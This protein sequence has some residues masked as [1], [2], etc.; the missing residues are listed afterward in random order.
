LIVVAAAAMFAAPGAVPAALADA[1]PI[2]AGGPGGRIALL[3]PWT[4]T[5]DSADHGSLKGWQAGVFQGTQVQVPFVPNAMPIVGRPGI[6]SYRGTVAWYRT[7]FN[8]PSDGVY[9]LHFES[10]HHHASIWLDDRQLGSHTG[11]YLP[12]EYRVSLQARTPHTLVVRADWRGPAAM[13]RAGWHRTWFNFGG[14]NREVT[15]R[16]V[17]ASDLSAPTIRTRLDG[18]TALVDVTVHVRNYA[19][20]RD[21]PIQGSL[22]RGDSSYPLTFP[23]LRVPHGQT[24]LVHAQVSVPDAALWSPDSPSRYDLNLS[25]PGESSYTTK[26]GLRELTW[27]GPHLFLNGQPLFLKGASIQEDAEGRGDALT[28][29]DMDT[30]V[31]DLKA[32]GANATRS[33]HPL[34]PA[35]LERFDAAGI[36]VWQGIGPVDA[37]G[38]WTS[39]TRAK[40]LTGRKRVRATFFQAQTHPSIIAWNLANEVAGNGHPGGQAQFI[41]AMARELHRR[42]PG[43]LVALDVWGVHPPTAPGLMY[44]DIDAIGATNYVGWYES[45]FAPASSLRRMIRS[46]IRNLERVFAGKVLVVSEF[47]AEASAANANDKPGGFA[48][49]S[50]LLALHIRTYRQFAGLSGIL[51]WNLRDFAVAPTFAGGSIHKLVPGI[52]IVRGLNQKGLFTYDG[53]PKPAVARVKRL[54]DRLQR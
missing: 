11:A 30:I 36:M 44:D 13:K 29:A 31:A 15:I 9:A 6:K 26:V 50:R 23:R 19:P 24:R 10:V 20:D 21:V 28:A 53:Q 5:R 52:Q 8:V 43:R 42:D 16:P 39:K 35:L 3:G 22:N 2:I 7:S 47:G 18:A 54:F 51:I 49:Q 38:S 33:Q 14:I 25:V 12:F 45:P 27:D 41:S 48:F 17:G 37:P 1:T 40:R 34:N 4:I 46:K 32:I